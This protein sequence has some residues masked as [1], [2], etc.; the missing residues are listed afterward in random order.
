MFQQRFSVV[1]H[2][3]VNLLKDS[4]N[5]PVLEL[6]ENYRLE[7]LHTGD[8]FLTHARHVFYA[9]LYL[10]FRR[11]SFIKWYQCSLLWAAWTVSRMVFEVEMVVHPYNPSTQEAEA[12]EWP[13]SLRLPWP[14]LKSLSVPSTSHTK[15]VSPPSLISKLLDFSDWFSYLSL[16]S[17]W[18]TWLQKWILVFNFYVSLT[19]FV[20]KERVMNA[21][22]GCVVGRRIS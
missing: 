10:S 21:C 9:E 2:F 11:W 4:V 6:K 15:N 20:Y 5:W 7:F 3:P 12:R 1:L 14:V 18:T 19:T 8:D 13:L 17:I 16:L 22:V